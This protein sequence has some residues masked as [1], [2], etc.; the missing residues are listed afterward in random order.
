MTDTDSDTGD[1]IKGGKEG[2]SSRPNANCIFVFFVYL[3]SFY[4]FLFALEFL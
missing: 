3:L 1:D 2:R 4:D